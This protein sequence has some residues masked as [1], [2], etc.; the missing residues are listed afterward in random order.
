[1]A[2]K[3]GTINDDVESVL[4]PFFC[5]LYVVWFCKF[6]WQSL[7]FGKTTRNKKTNWMEM[8]QGQIRLQIPRK[9]RN[10]DRASATIRWSF[11]HHSLS[12]SY[13]IITL[14]WKNVFKNSNNCLRKENSQSLFKVLSQIT[15]FLSK[16]G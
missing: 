14:A 2:E 5:Y 9:R 3:S 8:G 12:A 7:I 1:M 16:Y 6:Q 4:Y 15:S 11:R 10:R 13:H